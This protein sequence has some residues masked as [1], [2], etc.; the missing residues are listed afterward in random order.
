LAS[1]INMKNKSNVTILQHLSE[2]QDHLD[3]SRGVEN[4][5]E[6]LLTDL[7]HQLDA[8]RQFFKHATKFESEGELFAFAVIIIQSME[9]NDF[10]IRDLGRNLNMK[11]TK[12]YQN[13]F[14]LHLISLMDKNLIDEAERR[15]QG[16]GHYEV[17][18]SI[19]KSI[20]QNAPIKKVVIKQNDTLGVLMEI[21][22][23]MERFDGRKDDFHESFIPFKRNYFNKCKD[24]YI[25]FLRGKDLADIDILIMLYVSLATMD[26]MP[27]GFSVSELLDDVLKRDN[28]RLIFEIKK[29]MAKGTHILMQ[30]NLIKLSSE[31][32]GF[33]DSLRIELTDDV[34]S[35]LY[36]DQGINETEKVSKDLK[37]YKEEELEPLFF[38]PKLQA[39]IDRFIQM[40]NRVDEIDF[41]ALTTIFK[42]SPGTGKS[43]VVNYIAAKTNRGVY[44]VNISDFRNSFF[45]ESEKQTMKIFGKIEKMYKEGLKP[46]FLIE[47]IDAVLQKRQQETSSS[48]D[49]T[50]YRLANILLDRLS[51]LPRGCVLIGT[52]NFGE[53]APE[54]HRR[55]PIMIH[56]TL[57][58]YDCRFKQWHHLL[59]DDPNIK[60][61]AN[62]ELTPALIQN[63]V[64][65]MNTDKLIF[66]K[67]VERARVIQLIEKE[68][69]FGGVGGKKKVGF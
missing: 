7:K 46:I 65:Q 32:H 59:G 62:Y 30:K 5:L 68:V 42:G 20:L 55:F 36:K 54:Y 10:S 18:D 14:H 51:N 27:F 4:N 11:R 63:V 35:E 1:Q 34:K 64:Y 17:N 44:K 40:V 57:G 25:T 39:E 47:E 48:V 21:K 29:S 66:G 56:F 37:Y 12:L 28:L 19:M 6:T 15:R 2:I 16:F 50:E 31:G 61:Y 8:I 67:E 43:A 26:S 9:D 52:Q 69:E 60:D 41:P 24:P 3:N 33:N 53:L 45:G 58:D 38:D 49:S 22:N 13:N 23:F